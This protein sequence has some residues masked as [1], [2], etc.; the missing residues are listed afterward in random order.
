[1]RQLN[2]MALLAEEHLDR[3]G[4]LNALVSEQQCDR[5]KHLY[6]QLSIL[7]LQCTVMWHA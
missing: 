1:M 3:V 2:A 7:T 6:R 5:Q 4:V